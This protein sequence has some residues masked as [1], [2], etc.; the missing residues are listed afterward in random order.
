MEN[1][2]KMYFKYVRRYKK[3]KSITQICKENNIRSSNVE[4][5]GKIKKEKQDLL[6]K[7]MKK[8]VIKLYNYLILGVEI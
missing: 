2:N 6:I 8:E 1:E 5:R 3:M 4:I 7:E